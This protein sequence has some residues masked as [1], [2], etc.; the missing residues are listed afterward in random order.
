M[1]LA[2][3]SQSNS[4]GFQSSQSLFTSQDRIPDSQPKTPPNA[5]ETPPVKRLKHVIPR[6]LA[7]EKVV[8]INEV[9]DDIKKIKN[10]I[11]DL[12][13]KLQNSHFS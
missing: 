1:I 10:A 8:G 2:P 4:Q 12:E 3:D 5:I 7:D 13:Q 6:K 9:V 11:I